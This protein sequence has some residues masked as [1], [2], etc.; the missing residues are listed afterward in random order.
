MAHLL[1]HNLIKTI[2]YAINYTTFNHS[3]TF[4]KLVLLLETI[5]LRVHNFGESTKIVPYENVFH[6]NFPLL[7]SE[8]NF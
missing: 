2:K 1:D 8:R 7:P 3:S 5:N 6:E 4:T